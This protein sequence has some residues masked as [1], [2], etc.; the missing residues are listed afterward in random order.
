MDNAL[1]DWKAK[2]ELLCGRL[3]AC[4]EER[5]R[6]VTEAASWEGISER[7]LQMT[8]EW[9]ALS[10]E[11]SQLRE[12]SGDLEEADT[13]PVELLTKVAQGL[14]RIEVV[15]KDLVSSTGDDLRTAKDQRMLMSAYYGMNQRGQHAMYF[16]EKK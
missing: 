7:Y 11:F 9:D 10:I 1:G 16:D 15:L 5:L 14:E 13:V 8:G 2:Q 3:L 12:G 6:L 4:T